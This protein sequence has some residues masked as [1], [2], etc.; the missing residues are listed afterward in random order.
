MML[1]NLPRALVEE[2]LSRV[3]LKS[4]RAM[5]LTCKEWNTLLKSQSFT[6]TRIGKVAAEE[7]REL[8]MIVMMDYNV[9]LTS[10]VVVNGE[11]P[12]TK[13]LGKLAFLNKEEQVKISQ[14]FHC[15]GL[16]LCILKGD[17]SKLVV[18]NP[19]LCQTRLIKT[20]KSDEQEYNYKYAIGYEENNKNHRSY[21]ILRFRDH[22]FYDLYDFDSN[23]WKIH[24]LTASW[25]IA[26]CDRGVSLKGN[27]YWC[28]TDGFG[29]ISYT[30][31][32]D[33]T[34]MGFGGVQDLPFR[35][36]YKQ[37]VTLSCV[38]DEKLSVL[39][40]SMETFVID[41]W[42]TD[43][44]EEQ[45]VSWSKFLTVDMGPLADLRISHGRFFIDEEKKLAMVFNKDSDERSDTVKIFGEDGYFRELDLGEPSDKKCWPLVCSYVPSLVQIKLPEGG[46]KRKRESDD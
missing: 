5:R 20:R 2:T 17:T 12:R 29:I 38:R 41:I 36:P 13:P 21:K 8:W 1:S 31:C 27:T 43:K 6:R 23:S 22:L 19:Y 34:R 14:V 15:D 4:M 46:G 10:V 11:D 24:D 26:F 35:V 44:I 9:Y 3:P 33:F 40:Q 39:V 7:A 25:I 42:I 16:L 32:F 45:K 37:L 30:V 28:A 18:W